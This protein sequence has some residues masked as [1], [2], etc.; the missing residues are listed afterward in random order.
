[1]RALA[2][3]QGAYPPQDTRWFNGSNLGLAGQGSSRQTSGLQITYVDVAKTLLLAGTGYQHKPHQ[4]KPMQLRTRYDE[5]RPPF[6]R[7]PL[8]IGKW[9]YDHVPRPI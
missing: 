7:E 9:D 6:L 1:M 5:R 8:T 2:F 3:R 4:S